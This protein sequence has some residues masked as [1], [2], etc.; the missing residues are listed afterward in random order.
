MD[1]RESAHRLPITVSVMLASILQSIDTTIANVA[2]PHIRGSLSATLE[3]V[4]WVLTSYI[5]TSAIMT[6]LAGWLAGQYGRKKVLAF[7]V[8]A[9]TVASALCGMAHSL[10]QIVMFRALQGIGGAALVPL[11]QAVLLDINPPERHGRATA[12]W[13]MGVLVGP[14]IGPTLGGWLTDNYSWRWVFYINVPFGILSVLGVLTYLRETPRRGAPFDFFGFAFLSLAIGALQ[15]MLDRGQLLDWFSS[16]EICIEAAVCGVS[17]YL[18]VVH[19]LTARHPFVS[20]ALFRD[21]NFA[22]GSLFIFVVGVVLFATLALLPPLLQE[23]MG[24]PATTTGL[25]TSP[26]GIGA[27]VTMALVGR[28]IG[29]VDTRILIGAGLGVTALSLWFMCGFS[30]Q[31]D[32]RLVVWSGFLQGVGTG[33]AY[34]P[35]AA[36]SFATLAPYFRYEATAIFN[37]LRNVGSSIGISVV[38]ALLTRNTQV[39]HASLAAHVL[40]FGRLARS[41]G[42]GDLSSP[43]GLAALN[44]IVTRQAEWIA[45][46]DDFKLLLL[47]TLVA[48]PLLFM[49]RSG[50]GA[51]AVATVVAE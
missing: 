34:V 1:P 7:S 46:L 13:A 39:A 2:L 28:L 43:H 19:T 38:E 36:V 47:L 17:F 26:R 41:S 32:E 16:A 22:V 15:I 20:P 5:V 51:G 31:M 27:F 11:S 40:P 9:F 25:V 33:F 44:A 45:Y 37:L 24:Y 35:L 4:G 14:I 3:Q 42:A 18:F 12:V 10:T 49:L 6:P 23:L 30:P 50:R 21:R 48:L 8:M 29:R